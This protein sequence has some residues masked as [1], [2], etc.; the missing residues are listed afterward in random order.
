MKETT[1]Y[2]SKAW[3][4]VQKEVGITHS[5]YTTMTLKLLADIHVQHAS[6]SFILNK[7]LCMHRENC[8]DQECKRSVLC[9]T[10]LVFEPQ[11]NP[12]Q[13]FYIDSVDWVFELFKTDTSYDTVSLF[14]K[15]DE[16]FH[17]HRL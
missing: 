9:Q 1:D 4:F 10:K 13:I 15:L 3:D 2:F 5:E 17:S 7:T 16:H 8:V 12:H 14:V 11:L 6:K